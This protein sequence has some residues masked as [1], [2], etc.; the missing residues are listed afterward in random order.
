MTLA[1]ALAGAAATATTAIP[2][3]TTLLVAPKWLPPHRIA[4]HVACE[5]IK[6]VPGAT[7]PRRG[8]E[9]PSGSPKPTRLVLLR[10][11]ACFPPWPSHNVS[12]GNAHDDYGDTPPSCCAPPGRTA[13]KHSRQ[14]GSVPISAPDS[15]WAGWFPAR[16]ATCIIL[17]DTCSIPGLEPPTSC[18]Q[19]AAVPSPR[20]IRPDVVL[21]RGTLC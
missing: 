14:P 18:L 7:S 10:P 9:Q 19:T 21:T 12:R 5:R 3:A 6:S 15:E 20:K 1:Q 4:A 8:V 16:T 17:G 2:A 13:H 11:R